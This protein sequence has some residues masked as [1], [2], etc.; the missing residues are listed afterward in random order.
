MIPISENIQ[1]IDITINDQKKLIDIAYKIYPPEYQHLWK[2]DDCNWYLNRCYGLKNFEV[3][4]SEVHSN[5]YFVLYKSKVEGFIRFVH[6][7]P[8]DQFSNKSATYLHRI[9]VSQKCQ[10]TGIAQQ[11]IDWIVQQS[12]EKGMDIIWLEA[13][14]TKERALQFYKKNNF[15]IL[16]NKRLDFELML[17]PYRG[18]HLMYKNIL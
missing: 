13:M 9:Y 8:L 1:L 2:S 6:N 4:L 16:T 7:K 14:D 12:K 3:E 5:Y 18:M 10:G 11:L 17:S 15:K